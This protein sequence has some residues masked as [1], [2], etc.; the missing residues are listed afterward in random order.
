M[1]Y[2]QME[3][4]VKV[5]ITIFPFSLSFHKRF[6]TKITGQAQLSQRLFDIYPGSLSGSKITM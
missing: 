1:K 6:A 5:Q 2:K 4:I 3:T